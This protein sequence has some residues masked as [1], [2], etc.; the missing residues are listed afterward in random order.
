M[1]EAFKVYHVF[2][3]TPRYQDLI[4]TFSTRQAAEDC[5][6]LQ[7]AH[8]KLYWDEVDRE[9]HEYIIREV[10]PAAEFVIPIQ[11]RIP[12][13]VPVI[14]YRDTPKSWRGTTTSSFRRFR[15]KEDFIEFRVKEITVPDKEYPI[16]SKRIWEHDFV[17]VVFIPY[18][19]DWV[20]EKYVTE[21]IPKAVAYY[22]QY[23]SFIQEVQSKSPLSLF[24]D[25]HFTIQSPTIEKVY[26]QVFHL[27]D[28]AKQGFTDAERTL[29]C[30]CLQLKFYLREHEII[31]TRFEFQ[32]PK[33]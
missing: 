3:S 22:K 16:L 26:E 24:R 23:S 1:E 21:A 12:S 27:I 17:I 13:M 2:D 10:V 6:A 28:N 29:N 33:E 31:D 32:I 7:N 19:K 15:T 25:Y 14:C 20:M 18:N 30:E 4:A 9:F 5:V 8:K 11:D